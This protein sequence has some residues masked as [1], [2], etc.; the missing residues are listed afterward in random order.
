MRTRWVVTFVFAAGVAL[1][2][3]ST[4]AGQG[5]PAAS[6]WNPPRTAD[7]QPDFEGIWSEPAGGADGTNIET[8]FQTIDTLR[9]QG[10]S[11]ERIKARKPISAIVDTPDGRIPYQPWARRGAGTS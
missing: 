8:S 4:A 11:E 7:G 5:T 6:G 3:L 1:L 9:V 2:S 10:W